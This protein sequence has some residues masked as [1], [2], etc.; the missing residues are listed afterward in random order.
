MRLSDVAEVSRG[1]SKHRPRN[2]KILYENGKIPLIQTG[3]V[4]RANNVIFDCSAYYN[5]TGLAQSRLWKR[6]TLCLTIAANIADVA[7]LGIDACF[8][9]SVVGI[10]GYAPITSNKYFMYML[11]AFQE[12]LDS[13]ATKSAQKNLSVDTILSV[14]YPLPPLGEQ[15]RIVKRVEELLA[16]CDELKY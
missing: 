3:D 9:D 15:K 1:R 8:P 12:I 11:E 2:D 13:K 4:A 14:A 7:I 10:N 16:L 6:D 5:E